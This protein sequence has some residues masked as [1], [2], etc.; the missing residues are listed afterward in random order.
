MTDHPAEAART[1]LHRYARAVDTRDEQ[2]LATVFTGEVVLERV[3]GARTGRDTVLAF[4]RGVFD[5]P[6]L[7]SKHLVTNVV[8]EPDGANGVAVTAYFQAVSRT[9]DEAIAIYGEYDD[10]LVPGPA[11]GAGLRIARKR[12]DVQQVFTLEPR[13]V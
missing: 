12:I 2:A 9:A 6:T 11:A 10:V 8:A 5:G 7:W 13:H 4:Y 1:A 3:D